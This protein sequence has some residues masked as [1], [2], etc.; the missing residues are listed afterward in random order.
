MYQ[1]FFLWP[2]KHIGPWF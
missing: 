2:S 1:D